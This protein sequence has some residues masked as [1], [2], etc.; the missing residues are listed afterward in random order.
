M[1]Y[2][3]TLSATIHNVESETYAPYMAEMARTDAIKRFGEENI[4]KLGLKIYTTLDSDEQDNC[5]SL[6]FVIIY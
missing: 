6:L 4:Y 3:K 1:H 5:P 2:K